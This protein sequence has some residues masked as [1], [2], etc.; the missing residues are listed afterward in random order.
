MSFA[1]LDDQ[2]QINRFF[3]QSGRDGEAAGPL[4]ITDS[5]QQELAAFGRKDF[6]FALLYR[7]C[8]AE[9]AVHHNFTLLHIGK[10]VDTVSQGRAGGAEQAER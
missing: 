1:G 8:P 4:G 2:A 3:Q 7:F 10:E 9:T 5:L 6:N